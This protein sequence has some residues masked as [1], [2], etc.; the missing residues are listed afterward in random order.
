MAHAQPPGRRRESRAKRTPLQALIY[1][2]LVLGVWGLIFLIAFFAVGHHLPGFMRAYGDPELFRR[3]WRAQLARLS[4]SIIDIQDQAVSLAN[5]S[6]YDAVSTFPQFVRYLGRR[7]GKD[8]RFE[9]SGEDV[10]RL[11]GALEPR[12]AA[13]ALHRRGLDHVPAA[14]GHAA[15]GAAGAET[16]SAR[17]RCTDA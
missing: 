8:V 11:G 15:H 4:Q 12:V 14:R 6:F 17:G 3:S 10:S 9:L 1:W 16:P 5:V 2:T 7:S 13:V